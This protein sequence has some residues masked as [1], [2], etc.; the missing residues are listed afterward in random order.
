MIRAALF[1][2]DGL[3]VDSERLWDGATRDAVERHGRRYD[4]A[5]VA[6]HIGM[7]LADV[8]AFLHRHYRLPGTAEDFGRELVEAVRARFAAELRPMPGAEAAL[9]LA[10]DLGLARGLASSSPRVLIDAALDRCGWTDVFSAVLSGDDVERGKPHPDIFLR[11]AARLGAAPEACVVL[12]DSVNGARAAKA[13]GMR[14]I[15]VPHP[16]M[17]RA[18]LAAD[19]TLESLTALEAA[20]LTGS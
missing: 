16:A 7:R 8:T 13:A 9:A 2:L 11:A 14:C 1:D 5:E 10:L 4:G 19:V 15:A 3:L 20:H 17:D 18:A 6:A 12:E